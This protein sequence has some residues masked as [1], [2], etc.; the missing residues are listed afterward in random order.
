[1]REARA[2]Q[3]S[4][5]AMAS[6]S[7]AVRALC[8]AAMTGQI[9]Q[10]RAA[11]AAGAIGTEC[12]PSSEDTMPL[13]VACQNCQEEMAAWLIGRG[14]DVNIST[15]E[16]QMTALHTAS[17]VGYAPI[18]TLLIGSDADVTA[19][20]CEEM[21]PM[22]LACSFGHVET[23]QLLLDASASLDAP[24]RTGRTPLHC[25][26]SKG[27]LVVV[28]WLHS[29][30]ATIDVPTANLRRTALHV[31]RPPL[32]DPIRPRRGDA[33]SQH[34]APP[35]LTRARRACGGQ[36]ACREGCVEIAQFLVGAGADI[37]IEA[38]KHAKEETLWRPLHCTPAASRAPHPHASPP[39]LSRV[40]ARAR[41]SRV[42]KGPLRH[43]AAAAH[44]ER[45]AGGD[46]PRHDA[47]PP[48]VPRWPRAARAVAAG[49]GGRRGARR[50]PICGSNAETVSRLVAAPS[51]A[52]LVCVP[53]QVTDSTGCT[54]MHSACIKGRLA[55]AQWLHAQGAA[56]DA[57]DQTARTPLHHACQKGNHE[58]VAWLCREGA[59]TAART[60]VGQETAADLLQARMWRC[61]PHPDPGRSDDPDLAPTRCRSTC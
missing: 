52:R 19:V 40:R 28:E 59:D 15:V 42:R 6:A 49:L 13:H 57:R 30:G 34:A 8:N 11:V 5:V 32:W 38:K 29:S 26:A 4:A 21:T 20:E 27:E 44:G 18:V 47:A 48:G 55:T 41:R 56:L 16:T 31:R 50:T 23:A 10:A 9:E 51:R 24:T 7:R 58:I 17:M 36:D 43:R 37:H 3:A 60:G 35:L 1:M 33:H 25:A 14:V 2:A 12:D 54:P 39:P 53:V 46:G 61:S 45:D 22:H